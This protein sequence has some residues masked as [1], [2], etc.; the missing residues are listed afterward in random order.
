M[1]SRNAPGGLVYSTDAGRMCPGCRQPISRCTCSAK[2]ARPASDGIV[3]VTRETGGRN[4]KAVTVIKGL[5]LGAPA[6][7]QLATQ[8]KTLCGSGGTAKE[9]VVELQGD[10]REKV[11]AHLSK[12]GWTVKRAGG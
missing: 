10:H 12:A 2:T 8:L 6:L 1:K 3:R 5:P 9:G 7:A 4:G 11:I